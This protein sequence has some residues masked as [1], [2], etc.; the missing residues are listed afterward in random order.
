MSRSSLP[1]RRPSTR[2]RRLLWRGRYLSL[3]VAALVTTAV[4]LGELRPPDPATTAVVV[5]R[6]D[7]PGGS[8]LTE[9]DVEVALLP[10]ELAG[11]QM[12]R[13]SR[14]VVGRQLALG[15]PA[16]FPVSEQVL[17]GPGLVA[18]LAPGLVLVPVRLADPA[19]A[20]TLHPGDRVD[21]VA[22]TADAAGGAGS[23][24]V[25][26]AGALVVTR[27]E[28]DAAGL[29]SSE[30]APLVF[31]AIPRAAVAP[32]VGASAWAPLRIVLTG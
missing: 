19:V 26:A 10:P 13:S 32:V 5:L 8:E 2:L 3:V 27:A 11:P 28:Q 1:S 24:E 23:A 15:L 4:V 14:E 31:V 20:A 21:L 6:R 22:A 9:Q 18:G 16:G 17:V 12:A 25:V 7:V 30:Q 29:L